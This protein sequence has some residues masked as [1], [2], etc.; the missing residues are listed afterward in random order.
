ML[1]FLRVIYCF[2]TNLYD[3]QIKNSISKY[4]TLAIVIFKFI[5]TQ[6]YHHIWCIFDIIRE[7]SALRIEKQFSFY[8]I[9]VITSRICCTFKAPGRSCLFAN[10]SRVAPSN[11]SSCNNACNSFLQSS[12]KSFNSQEIVE[13]I[14]KQW[15]KIIKIVE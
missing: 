2:N 15:N 9:Q 3:I 10:T 13:N 8:F 14:I 1:F 12:T 11:L 4:R 5:G 6:N 7:K